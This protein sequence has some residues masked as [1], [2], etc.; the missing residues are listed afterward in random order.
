MRSYIPRAVVAVTAAATIA[1]AGCSSGDDGGSSSATGEGSDGG[2]GSITFAMGSNDA[3]KVK[4]LIEKWNQS[5][6]DQQVEFKELPA[7]AD[8]QH[9]KLVQ[10]LQ[11][12]NDDYDVMAVDVTWTAEFAANGWIAPLEGDL[13]LDTSKL[14]PATVESA[15]YNGKLYAGPQ[16]TNAQLLYYRTDLVEQAPA[17]WDDLTASCD[18]AKAA[19]VDCM[20]TQLKNYEGLT[21]NATQF[22]NSWGG[23]VVG[24]DGK[25]PTVDSPE[26]KAGL[27]ALVDGYKNGVIAKRSNGFDE[28]A[29]NNAFVNGEAMYATNWP[30]MYDNAA[31]DGTG[32]KPKSA[33]QGKF[34][35]API[36]GE[37]GPGASTLGGY[38]L[39][40]NA[41]SKAKS[42]ALD[43]IRFIE[44]PESQMSFAE[45][46]FPPVLASIY[47]DP[48][49]AEQYPYM[50]VLK[51]ALE[52]AKPRPVTPFYSEVSK[53][54]R[55][56]VYASLTAGKSIDQA[57]TDISTVIKNAGQ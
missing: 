3:G 54:I 55:D 13:A 46:A 40:I 37:N 42:T 25:T 21:V 33:V 7:D 19:G 35:V 39:A 31:S 4:P 1:L 10:S 51:Q 52:T 27:T 6:P 2:S 18:K 16:N 9:D 22:I 43:F 56:N 23:S 17:T 29:T 50:P 28:E 44:S 26:A 8:G 45:N 15:T 36:V 57:V 53:G 11:A 14:L 5:H 30:Y 34:A 20:V 32:D 41:N 38:N 47:D 49:L 12:G 48:A 24:P